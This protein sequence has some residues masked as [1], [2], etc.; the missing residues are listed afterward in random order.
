MVL[1]L[2]GDI[3][4]FFWFY[5]SLMNILWCT[6]KLLSFPFCKSLDALS[7]SWKFSFFLKPWNEEINHPQFNLTL[8][9]NGLIFIMM[10]YLGWQTF[11]YKLLWR[12]S[13]QW[14]DWLLYSEQSFIKFKV[15][16]ISVDGVWCHDRGGL[17]SQRNELSIYFSLIWLFFLVCLS[18]F[19]TEFLSFIH[20]KCLLP[21]LNLH[22]VSLLNNFDF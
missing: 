7:S 16:N 18:V 13:W 4:L 20:N 19:L 9:S 1:F 11:T 15:S 6:C 21:S 3:Y 5:T 17:K 8:C 10:S 12:W 14:I 2:G 22:R